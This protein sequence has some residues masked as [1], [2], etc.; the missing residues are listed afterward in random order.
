MTISGAVAA[1]LS[2][3]AVLGTG[4][5]GAEGGV[6][7]EGDEIVLLP[8]CPPPRTAGDPG[9]VA[10]LRWLHLRRMFSLAGRKG[11]VSPRKVI[12][13]WKQP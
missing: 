1:V 5:D 12:Y 9:F 8:Q 4:R 7:L 3:P 6:T 13:Q 10:S 2:V 11:S